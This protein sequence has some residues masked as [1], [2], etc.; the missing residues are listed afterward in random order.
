MNSTQY[1][2]D[3]Q[4]QLF[5]DECK[6]M[7]WWEIPDDI[8]FFE[9]L[10]N[11][12]K[13]KNNKITQMGAIRIRKELF[14]KTGRID[15]INYYINGE[16]IE[17]SNSQKPINSDFAAHYN[18]SEFN[19]LCGFLDFMHGSY[20]YTYNKSDN[21]KLIELVAK[22]Y[23]YDTYGEGLDLIDDIY[24]LAK[25]NLFEKPFPDKKIESSKINFG[26]NFFENICAVKKSIA[27]F[28]V[29]MLAKQI[30][31]QKANSSVIQMSLVM[32][33]GDVVAAKKMLNEI[34][35]DLYQKNKK[36]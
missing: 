12:A 35:F 31:F 7:Y 18:N 25:K 10:T 30:E 24:F 27:A 23:N 34:F 4:S 21:V 29:Y 1:Q 14:F 13:G 36:G 22:K 16:F 11:G 19:A 8:V 26:V 9:F 15:T 5:I 17:D 32:S 6:D 28:Y 20:A 3:P 33:G 2:I